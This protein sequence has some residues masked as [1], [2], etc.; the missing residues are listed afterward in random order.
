MNLLT[1]VPFAKG[2]PK[3][4]LSYFSMKEIP[5]LSTVLVSLRNR[6]TLGL[7]VESK[8][9]LDS[10][11]EVKKAEF[12]LKKI[13]EV[14]DQPIFS[15]AFLKS[16]LRTAEYFVAKKS[17]TVD[18]LIPSIFKEEYDKVAKWVPRVEAVATDPEVKP[19]KLLFQAKEEERIS[20]YKTLI[21]GHFAKKQSV[22]IVVPSITH[23]EAFEAHLG[24]GIEQ[25]T[26]VFSSDLADKKILEKTKNLLE[27]EHPVLIISTPQYLAIPRNDISTIILEHEN[28]AWRTAT[29][30]GLDLRYFVETLAQELQARLILADT[31][32]RFE[33][34]ARKEN[35]NLGSV[36]N[37][38][39]RLG[40]EG[41]VLLENKKTDRDGEQY[42]IFTTRTIGEIEKVLN[43]KKNV[44]VFSLRKGL[45]TM[46]ICRDC[47][48][49]LLCKNCQAPIVLYLSK[50]KIKRMYSCN[51]C[52]KEESTKEMCGHCG[53]WNLE[54]YGIGTDSATAELE[55]TFPKTPIYKL[56]KNSA[57]SAS[58][59]KK[60]VRDFENEKGA[61]LVGTELALGYL[62]N[63]VETSVIASFD[64]LWSIP[65][66]RMS[67]KIISIVFGITQKTNK[68]LLIQTKNTG[69]GALD[70][71]SKDN[72]LGFVRDELATREKLG[73]PPYKKFI[74]LTHVGENEDKEKVKEFLE[75][76]FKEYN[77]LVYS[78]FIEKIKGKYITHTLLKVEPDVWSIDS[79]IGKIKDLALYKKINALADTF[80]INIEPDDLL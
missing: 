80:E 58:Q 56:D 21:R 73:Y 62:N 55:N 38:S 23:V 13:L 22:W 45:G 17:Y 24:R 66:F 67:E 60:I 75:E 61:I 2:L 43:S 50:D 20:Y 18:T 35:E 46:T 69:D 32:L 53:S 51:K 42:K 63:E 11:I 36:R 7:V 57:K 6:K 25:F 65:N 39:F 29:K 68:L 12:N 3:G 1:I 64:S 37:E 40:F 14:K 59:A 9:I 26:F 33:T 34:L 4:E 19:E 77:P 10:K 30:P 74:K 76:Y 27:M 72:L 31:I 47:G 71:I 79:K 44:F 78:A 16:A 48:E 49:T 41:E 15:E 28:G 52:G 70:A 54:S 5:V 8:S